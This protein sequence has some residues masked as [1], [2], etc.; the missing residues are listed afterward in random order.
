LCG[1]AIFAL[2]ETAAGAA[3]APWPTA[4]HDSRHSGTAPVAGPTSGHILWERNLGGNVTPGPAVGADGTIYIATNAGVLH[5][6]N[7]ATGAD[8]WTFDGG[9]P[10]IGETDLSTTPLIL[11]SGDIVWSGP[12]HTLFDLSPVGTL[13]WS[14]VFATNP[15]SPVLA[16]TRV[17]IEQMGG[18]L[19]AV[20]ISSATPT[21]VW[22]LPIGRTSFGSPVVAPNGSI[23]TTAD[24]HVVDVTDKGGVGKVTWTFTTSA[25]LEVSASVGAD[26]TVVVST[27]NRSVYAIKPNGSLKWR[28]DLGSESYSSASVS[29]G[30]AYFGD[31]S[32]HLHVV[33]EQN[34][35]PIVSDRGVNGIWS[36]QAIDQRGDV[37]FGT[38]GRQIYGYTARGK[39]LF[40]V[41]ASGPIDSYPALT[42]GGVLIIG[43]QAGTLYAIG[44]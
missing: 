11:S 27:N 8:K 44:G 1:A 31:N 10:Y 28:T 43:D 32:G 37:Y 36:A 42:A 35:R 20:D 6:L 15:L 24:R 38:Q 29:N 4:L 26:G 16:G 19:S 5:A 2:T 30:V 14:H 39:R 13:I 7:P 9:G 25:A 12:E 21:V 41:T 17:Y 18:T 3:G 40:D 22:S 34:G 33:R 23:V